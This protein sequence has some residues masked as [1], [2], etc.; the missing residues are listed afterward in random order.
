MKRRLPGS[1]LMPHGLPWRLRALHIATHGFGTE[2]LARY[3]AP[4]SEQ[5]LRSRP[6]GG[7]GVNRH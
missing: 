1:T 3:T 6:E 5:R 2:F 7:V 4:N